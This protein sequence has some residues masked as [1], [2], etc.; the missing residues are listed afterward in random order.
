MDLSSNNKF[1]QIKNE[2]LL[3]KRYGIVKYNFSHMM[4]NTTN[5]IRTSKLKVLTQSSVQDLPIKIKPIDFDDPFTVMKGKPEYKDLNCRAFFNYQ[6]PKVNNLLPTIACIINSD[7]I[8]ETTTLSRMIYPHL[9][10]IPCISEVNTYYIKLIINGMRRC[11]PVDGVINQAIFY[12]KKHEIYPFLIEKA[13]NKIYSLKQLN[14]VEPNF[15]I[16]RMV[17][18]IPE[19]LNYLEIGGVEE[20]FDKLMKNFR[21]FTVMLSFDFRGE[22]LPILDFKFDEINEKRVIKTILPQMSKSL[23]HLNP[24]MIGKLLFLQF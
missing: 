19:T 3:K 21:S 12:T 24:K 2:L 1:N 20:S 16:Y 22:I 11:F 10:H 9:N 17:G 6:N 5:D 15:L 8:F 4:T 23:D 7:Q 14:K 18:W 13:L